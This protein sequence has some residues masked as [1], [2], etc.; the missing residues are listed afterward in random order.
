MRLRVT[1]TNLLPARNFTFSKAAQY[2]R[3]LIQLNILTFL[4]SRIKI[5]CHSRKVNSKSFGNEDFS[6]LFVLKT[7]AN[8]SYYANKVHKDFAQKLELA[9]VWD[10]GIYAGQQVHRDHDLDDQDNDELHIY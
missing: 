7:G 6:T 4:L 9:R 3:Q 8:I 1:V 5:D 2:K 10:K